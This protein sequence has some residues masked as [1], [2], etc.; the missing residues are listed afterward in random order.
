[1]DVASPKIRIVRHEQVRADSL[2]PNPKN[3]RKHPKAQVDATRAVIERMGFTSP[4]M[5]RETTDGLLLL[6]G[7]LRAALDPTWIV[8]VD[9]VDLDEEEGDLSLLTLDPLSAM[10]HPDTDSLMAL[11]EANRFNNT[12][13]ND[14]LEALANGATPPPSQGST[15]PDDVPLTQEEPY[16]Q[17]GD[18][19]QCGE[20]RVMCG[21]S[22]EMENV[23]SLMAE[24]QAAMMWTDPPYGVGYVGKTKQAMTLSNDDG[25]V[26]SLLG[27]VFVQ[28][29]ASLRANARIYLAAPPG[30]LNVTFRLAFQAIGWAFHQG[31]IWVKDTMVLGHSDHHI[32]HEDILYGWKPGPGRPG[33]GN[34]KGAEWYGGND[35]TTVFEI[36]RPKRSSEHPTMK[37]VALV[38]ANL[39][40]SSRRDDLILDLFLGSG[41]TLIACER[42][43]RVCYG[44]EIESRY[45]QVAIERWQNYTG[46]KAVKVG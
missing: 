26:A 2:L 44:M 18:I 35:Q 45:V 38:E 27:A 25:E 13:V 7:H 21:D 15:D 19:W 42:L 11:L 32:R 34:H 10:A 24:K 12:A 37:P 9:V 41:T 46:K 22:R 17:R 30:P 8:P 29:N 23:A 20:H 43:G 40:N 4:L 28:A 16:V 33:R 6:D 31:L 1:M 14:M 36:P 5:A 3:W 39:R